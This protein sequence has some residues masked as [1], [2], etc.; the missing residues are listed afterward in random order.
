VQVSLDPPGAQGRAGVP[1]DPGHRSLLDL[2]RQVSEAPGLRLSGL[3]AVAPPRADPSP[4]FAAL[5]EATAAVRA[6]HPS[7]R[8]LSAGM[9]GDL[10][11]AI[12]YGST[13]VRVGTAL[14]GSRF[15][16]VV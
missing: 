8:T 7:A 13:H 15:V 9:S 14:L 16:P 3:M 10:E 1:L 6:E 5:A 12:A 2:C 11:Q 4:A